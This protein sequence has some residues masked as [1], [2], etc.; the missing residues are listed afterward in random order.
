MK[1]ILF[2]LTLFIGSVSH[3]QEVY[4]IG[5]AHE[6]RNY[7]NPDSLLNIFNKKQPDLLLLELE[8]IH[9]TKDFR[10]DTSKYSLEDFLT[11]NENIAAY[12]YQQQCK[13]ELRPFDLNGRHDFYKKEDYNN[14]ENKLFTEMMNL[15]K[16]DKLSESCKIDF[17]ILLAAL[18]SY[19]DLNFNSL[20]E[21]NSDVATRFISLKNKINFEMM[22]SIVKRTK[23]L[24][25]W[26]PFA[27]LRSGYWDKRNK[28]MAEN[29]I[30]YA[31]EFKGKK[32][33]VMV[34]NDHKYAL[35]ELLKQ[36]NIK[37][38]DCYE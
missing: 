6:E 14:K 9:F 1:K 19:S 10:F 17:E 13:A 12:K 5:T 7:I 33:I 32:I 35:L 38:R 37:I 31:N 18:G 25:H 4:L 36:N 27:E 29:I 11:S 2:A 21:A 26:L 28:A 15:Y 23:R 22:I 8:Y 34:G 30:R 20:K 16:R 24:K 3:S